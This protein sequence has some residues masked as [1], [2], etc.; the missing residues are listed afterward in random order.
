MNKELCEKLRKMA[1]KEPEPKHGDGMLRFDPK[2]IL[3]AAESFAHVID[4]GLPTDREELIALLWVF[5][6][7][8]NG[9]MQRREKAM[10]SMVDDVV[11]TSIRPLVI[12]AP[13]SH[14]ESQQ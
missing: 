4:Y 12:P 6:E 14:K 7:M 3:R 11:A 5:G 13:E 10:M 9:E 1:P 8:L 2:P